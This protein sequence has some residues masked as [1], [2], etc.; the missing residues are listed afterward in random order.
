MH[1]LVFLPLTVPVIPSACNVDHHSMFVTR[2]TSSP[3]YVSK[4]HF[5]IWFGYNSLH[6]SFLFCFVVRTEILIY[7]IKANYNR[8]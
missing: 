4:L 1:E 7:F 2:L 3:N 5:P 6:K 8:I